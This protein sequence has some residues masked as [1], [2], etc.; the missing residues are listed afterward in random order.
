MDT[1]APSPVRFAQEKRETKWDL[2]YDLQQ[3]G[4]KVWVGWGQAVLGPSVL[5]HAKPQ[6]EK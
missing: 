3:C 2:I 1:G 6:S 4:G 5:T